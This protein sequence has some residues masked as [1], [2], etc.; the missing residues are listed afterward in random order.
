MSQTKKITDIIKAL[1]K[2]IFDVSH[3]QKN[4]RYH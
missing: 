2:M 4:H 3:T 1:N